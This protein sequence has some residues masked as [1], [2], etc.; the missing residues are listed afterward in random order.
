[1]IKVCIILIIILLYLWLG[2]RMFE[3][4]VE[5]YGGKDAYVAEIEKEHPGVNPTILFNLALLFL[6]LFW[7]YFIIEGIIRR[8][9]GTNE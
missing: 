2:V 9:I 7:P 4:G 5:H 8:L 6:T 3:L 1:M